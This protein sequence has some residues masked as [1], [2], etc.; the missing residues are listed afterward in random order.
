LN[1]ALDTEPIFPAGERFS[2]SFTGYD[3]LGLVIEKVTGEDFAPYMDTQILPE[4]GMSGASFSSE[5]KTI[6]PGHVEGRTF[7]EK[8]FSV[9]SGGMVATLNQ[10][11]DFV[12]KLSDIYYSASVTPWDR[13]DIDSIRGYHNGQN[14]WPSGVYFGLGSAINLHRF[15]SSGPVLGMEGYTYGSSAGFYYLPE[16]DVGI[17]FLSNNLQVPAG[18]LSSQI[19]KSLFDT[20]NLRRIRKYEP[21]V[22]QREPLTQP[23]TLAE[24]GGPLLRRKLHP[25]CARR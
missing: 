23:L 21:P 11:S 8:G 22:T 2:Y 4:L 15:A 24:A 17:A 7:E 18:L 5:G 3:I 14:L 25:R 1:F 20:K 6:V 13:E 9:P 10:L 16:D 12:I 19:L